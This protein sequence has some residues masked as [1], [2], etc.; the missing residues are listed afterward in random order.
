[1]FPNFFPAIKTENLP[2]SFVE[3]CLSAKDGKPLDDWEVQI[4]I[5]HKGKLF[6]Y[7]D[8]AF[9]DRHKKEISEECQFALDIQ[10]MDQ[11]QEN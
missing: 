5:K 9:L 11:E 3:H 6:K 7:Q 4:T 2:C 10:S 1:M 8:T